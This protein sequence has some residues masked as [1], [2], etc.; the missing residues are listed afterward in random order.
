MEFLRILGVLTELPKKNTTL[1]FD[2]FWIGV[3]DRASFF[4]PDQRK[5]LDEVWVAGEPQW[6]V[7]AMSTN[8]VGGCLFS[9]SRAMQFHPEFQAEL[10]ELT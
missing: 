4:A 6:V 1:F 5:F 3:L 2:V 9:H 8:L 7:I 10:V